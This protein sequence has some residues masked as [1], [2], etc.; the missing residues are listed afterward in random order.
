MIEAT[1]TMLDSS[2]RFFDVDY[3]AFLNKKHLAALEAEISCVESVQGFSY[4]TTLNIIQIY[5]LNVFTL[6]LVVSKRLEL[7]RPD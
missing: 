2:F 5:K 4:F 7:Q 6:L 3:F 1:G